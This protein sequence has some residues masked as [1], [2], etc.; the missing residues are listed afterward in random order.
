MKSLTTFAAASALILAATAASAQVRVDVN[1]NGVDVDTGRR[2]VADN[3][4][5]ATFRTSTIVGMNVKNQAGQDLGEVKDLVVDGTGRIRYAALSY[6]GFLGFNDKL[7]AVP[8]NLL[9]I[10]NDAGS[11]TKF[12]EL[13][14]EKSYL[15]KAPGFPTDQWPDFGNEKMTNEVD[16]FY[17]NAN[18]TAAPRTTIERK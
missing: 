10:R 11:D 15:E 12:V 3:A 14:V 7:F 4:V 5:A 13:N 9:K 17:K 8:W 16:A 2:S 6:G 18:S 1:R